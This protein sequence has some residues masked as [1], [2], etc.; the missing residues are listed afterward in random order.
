VFTSA[1]QPSPNW[2]LTSD[3]FRILLLEPTSFSAILKFY[4]SHVY[5]C[6]NLFS[7]KTLWYKKIKRVFFAVY[8]FYAL[9]P[10]PTNEPVKVPSVYTCIAIVADNVAGEGIYSSVT[11]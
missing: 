7:L 6:N 9:P 2:V 5:V 10:V 11:T 4:A 1:S 3:T 8:L